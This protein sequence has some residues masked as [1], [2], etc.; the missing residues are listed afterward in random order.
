MSWNEF[1][2]LSVLL[3]SLYKTGIIVYFSYLLELQ[4]TSKSMSINILC[5]KRFNNSLMIAGL[6]MFPI[7]S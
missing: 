6:P 5:M 4:L 2:F 3:K 1:P 7:S